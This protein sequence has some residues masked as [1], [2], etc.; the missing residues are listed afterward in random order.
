MT[1][2]SKGKKVR[3]A[4]VRTTSW[5]VVTITYINGIHYMNPSTESQEEIFED[6]KKHELPPDKRRRAE[7]P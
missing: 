3:P 1:A 2:E 7:N 5:G 6:K 4:S